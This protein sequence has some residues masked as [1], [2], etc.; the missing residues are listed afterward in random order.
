MMCLRIRFPRYRLWLSAAILATVPCPELL[1]QPSWSTP[2]GSTGLTFANFEEGPIAL[3]AADSP[4][5]PRLYVGGN[6]DSIA[7]LPIRDLAVYDGR[8][9]SG[10]T[11]VVS[12][13]G[14]EIVYS[15]TTAFINGAWRVVAAGQFSAPQTFDGLGY[16]DDQH[17]IQP[18][19]ATPIS[20]HIWVGS[21]FGWISPSGPEILLS[22]GLFPIGSDY[23][24]RLTPTGY[25]PV[26]PGIITTA[27][28]YALFENAVYIAGMH[29]DGGSG[30]SVSRWDG[31]TLVAMNDGLGWTNAVCVH[32]DGTGP[33]LYTGG[34]GMRRYHAGVWEAVPG[35]PTVPVNALASYDD[36]DGPALYAAGAFTT[37]GGQAANRIVRLRNGQWQPLGLGLTGGQA[38]AMTTYDPDGDGPRPRALFVVGEF[39]HVDGQP[40]RGI[41]RWGPADFVCLADFNRQ[42]GISIDDLFDFLAAFFTGDPRG[43]INT[44]GAISVQDVFDFLAAYFSGC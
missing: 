42:G 27:G 34:F 44:S 7:G 3:V 2:A 20:P 25:A 17:V 21:A 35:A 28:G 31:S 30:R 37:A 41:G 5:G 33:A 24:Y 36:G 1:A 23:I 12:E 19:P 22:A 10:V 39:T 43:D 18:F 14:G 13:F 32:D 26:P 4:T 15:L 40:S 9:W 6:F 8:S 11:G 16:L 38:E 29:V